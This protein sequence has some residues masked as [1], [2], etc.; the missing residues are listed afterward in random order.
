MTDAAFAERV[1]ELANKLQ[2]VLLLSE[3]LRTLTGDVRNQTIELT[4]EI[5][6]ASRMFKTSLSQPQPFPRS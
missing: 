3:E 6:R 1:S 5:E 2:V 4:A